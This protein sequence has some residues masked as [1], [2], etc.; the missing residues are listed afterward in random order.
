[1][2]TS[3]LDLLLTRRS[4]SL[5]DLGEPGPDAAALGRILSAGTRVPDHGRLTPWH[6]QV[7]RA[8]GQRLLG[9]FVGDLYARE[10]PD[11]PPQRLALMRRY[12][13]SAP[14][15]LAVTAKLR[16]GH[17]IPEQE[18]LLS[19]GAVCQSLLLAAHAE[20]FAANWLTGWSS[21]R[22]EVVRVLGHDPAVDRLIGFIFIG[23]ARRRPDERPRPA[24]AEVTSEWRGPIGV[25]RLQAAAGE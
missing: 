20:G 7:L 22:P 2:T 1:M 8:E 10:V 25:E 6:I 3:N 24:L 21:Y 13:S 12:L 5:P 23:T 14:L 16:P 15:L 19:G 17:A 11:A 18:Q 9:E 4:V